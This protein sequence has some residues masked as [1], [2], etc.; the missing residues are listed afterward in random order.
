MVSLRKPQSNHIQCPQSTPNMSQLPSS[1]YPFSSSPFYSSTIPMMNPALNP[2]TPPPPP[3]KPSSHEASQGGT[4]QMNPALPV[5]SQAFQ[6]GYQT[7]DSARSRAGN[8]YPSPSPANTAHT[9]TPL[10]KPP[11][12]EEGW[13]PDAV[14]DKSWVSGLP[15]FVRNNVLMVAI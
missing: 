5:A 14:R 11:A 6:E 13:L 9:N 10:P 15:M 12:V 4:P 1:N 3:P 7:Q 2:H 8:A